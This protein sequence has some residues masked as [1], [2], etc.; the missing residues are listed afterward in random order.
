[1]FYLHLGNSYIVSKGITTIITYCY[2][3]RVLYTLYF[4]LKPLKFSPCMDLLSV[5]EIVS[6][7]LPVI[8]EILFDF[9]VS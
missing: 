1:M 4:Y 5:P 8:L 7:K 2:R 9:K 6:V 3:T